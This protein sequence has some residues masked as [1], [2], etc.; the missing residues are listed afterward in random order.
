VVKGVLLAALY[1]NVAVMDD[2]SAPGKHLCASVLLSGLGTLAA[3]PG[4][5]GFH[6]L[7]CCCCCCILSTP[8]C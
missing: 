1:P 2:E 3:G 7:R 6:M 5:A 4:R 8:G